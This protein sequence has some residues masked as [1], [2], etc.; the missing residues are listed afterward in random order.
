MQPTDLILVV[1]VANKSKAQG[2][3]LSRSSIHRL[4]ADP[5]GLQ[6]GKDLRESLGRWRE[7][8]AEPGKKHSGSRL[9]SCSHAHPSKSA[10]LSHRLP[11]IYL[12]GNWEQ[13]LAQALC[14]LA[15]HW[16]C[17]SRGTVQPSF[18]P[19]MPLWVS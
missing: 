8:I 9:L 5:D 16:T 15:L 6:A 7:H 13:N 3:G 19:Q 18:P 10:P 11:W 1:Q 12:E 14:S 4:A 2:F 17:K